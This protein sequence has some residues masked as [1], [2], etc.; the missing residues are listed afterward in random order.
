MQEIQAGIK[1]LG[2]AKQVCHRLI[3]VIIVVGVACSV[4]LQLN[5]LLVD[6]FGIFLRVLAKAY[7]VCLRDL[8]VHRWWGIVPSG[9]IW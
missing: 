4:S 9:K 3:V 7:D 1:I 5:S 2:R 6:G 8:A